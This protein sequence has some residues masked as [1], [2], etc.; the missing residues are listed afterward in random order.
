MFR[1]SPTHAAN[2]PNNE[3]RFHYQ[4]L[5]GDRYLTLTIIQNGKLV[6]KLTGDVDNFGTFERESPAKLSKD[7]RFAVINQIQSGNVSTPDGP[8]IYHE[9][10]YCNLMNVFSGCIITRE[11]GEFCSGKF[12]EVS[13]WKNPVYS[14]FNLY[15][16]TPKAEDYAQGR[17]QL[18]EYPDSSF[19]NLLVCD[20]PNKENANAYRTINESKI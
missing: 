15:S 18:S 3:V 19:A 17:R 4:N 5:V 12:S 9:V 11:T 16:E 2:T 6:R 14:D 10:A 1:I 20:P 8:S 13:E 7:G